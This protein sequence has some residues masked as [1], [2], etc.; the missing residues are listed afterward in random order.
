MTQKRWQELLAA[1]WLCGEAAGWHAACGN[2]QVSNG[3]QAAAAAAAVRVQQGGGGVSN[4]TVQSVQRCVQQDTVVCKE[5]NA[6]SSESQLCN[7]ARLRSGHTPYDCWRKFCAHEPRALS[8]CSRFS[9]R[10]CSVRAVQ[11]LKTRSVSWLCNCINPRVDEHRP[12][13]MSTAA[14]V[15]VSSNRQLCLVQNRAA[16]KLTLVFT[17]SIVR[18]T[19]LHVN[20][21]RTLLLGQRA[22]APRS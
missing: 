16:A 4:T 8:C 12:K 3:V 15:H 13:Q 5:P 2:K 10:W 14:A 17:A 22:P 21:L 9:Q 1:R 19:G 7:A 20:C 6:S 11:A 18:G